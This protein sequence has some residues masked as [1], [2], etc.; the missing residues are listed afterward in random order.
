MMSGLSGGDFNRPNGTNFD[1]LIYLPGNEL[2]GYFRMSLGDKNIL[3]ED[4]YLK[5]NFRLS[6]GKTNIKILIKF[7]Q[8]KGALFGH[9]ERTG[10][11]KSY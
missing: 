2:P 10:Q 1:F 6:P 11:K 9:F 7:H 5:W 3:I 8:N 4:N